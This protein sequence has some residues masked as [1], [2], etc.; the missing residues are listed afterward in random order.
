MPL[1]RTQP[2]D[3]AV[4][5]AVLYPELLGTYGDGG[6]ATILRQRLAWRGI[7]AEVT[8]VRAGEAV[9]ESCDLGRVGSSIA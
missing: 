3:G 1:E 9:P 6:N 2:P 7:G 8:E 5:I 4:S